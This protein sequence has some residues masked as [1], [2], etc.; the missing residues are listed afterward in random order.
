MENLSVSFSIAGMEK[1]IKKATANNINELLRK[2]R[3]SVEESVKKVIRYSIM[4]TEAWESLAGQGGQDSLMSHL[5]LRKNTVKST[6]K[7]ILDAWLQGVKVKIDKMPVATNKPSGYTI[8]AIRSDYGEVLNL[9][10]ASY[11][12]RNKTIP[13]LKWLLVENNEII[14][15]DFKMI[16]KPADAIRNS[17]SG[18]SIL[19]KDKDDSWKLPEKWRTGHSFIDDMIGNKKFQRMLNKAI[20][21]AIQK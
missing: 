11:K 3:S 1:A 14:I 5:G 21:K 12:A 9:P 2:R 20:I 19:T 4:M 17:R 6:L 13:W 8:M 18:F 15:T 7:K 16:F 10:D